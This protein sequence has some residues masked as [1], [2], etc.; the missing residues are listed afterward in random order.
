MSY[1]LNSLKLIYEYKETYI[2]IFISL[3][4]T[5]LGIF[6]KRLNYIVL[7]VFLIPYYLQIKPSIIQHLLRLKDINVFY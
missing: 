6:I 2:S 1:L 3:W 4:E 7:A 5:T